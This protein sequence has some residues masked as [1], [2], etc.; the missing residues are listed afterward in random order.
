ML[1]PRDHSNI[2]RSLLP[3]DV[4]SPQIWNSLVLV[5]KQMESITTSTAEPKGVSGKIIGTFLDHQ[6]LSH[7]HKKI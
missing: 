6:T 2:T 7:I 1:I 4:G 5:L 3:I